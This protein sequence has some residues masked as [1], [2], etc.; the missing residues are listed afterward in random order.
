VYRKFKITV[1]GHAYDVVVEEIPHDS[2]HA[3]VAHAAAPAIAAAS[4]LAAPA[5]QSHVAGA[6]VAPL[7]G[8]VISID[9]AIGQTIEAGAKIAMIEAMKMKTEVFA[10][11]A[12]RVASIAVKP[13]SRW[14]PAA[15]FS[16]S[17]D[18]AA[19]MTMPDSL[20][21]AVLLSVIDF[22]LSIAMISVIGVILALFPLLNRLG[23][24]DDSTLRDSQH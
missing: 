2:S 18:G 13:G 22:F 14:T 17:H 3:P 6:E 5:A 21:G 11:G 12:G 10:R 19:V 24:I 23:R 9:V 7:A 20:Y 4:P 1:D 16:C 8:V 15:S